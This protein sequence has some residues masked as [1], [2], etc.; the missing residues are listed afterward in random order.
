[1]PKYLEITIYYSSLGNVIF[2]MIAYTGRM[3]DNIPDDMKGKSDTPTAHHLFYIAEDETKI[4]QADADIFHHCL[5]QL[6]YL[7]KRSLPYIQL[8]VSFL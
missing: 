4:S 8:A 6:L 2:L 3:I 5:A 7:S 1:M